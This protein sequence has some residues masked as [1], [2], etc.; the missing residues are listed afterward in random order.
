[1]ASSLHLAMFWASALEVMQHFLPVAFHHGDKA[2]ATAA[3]ERGTE[4]FGRVLLEGEAPEEEALEEEASEEEAL[5]EEALAAEVVA[6]TETITARIDSVVLSTMRKE[7]HQTDKWQGV[8]PASR[9]AHTGAILNR[10][11]AEVHEVVVPA[12][13]LL[14]LLKKAAAV[15]LVAE[16][17]HVIA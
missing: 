5:E 7:P 1:M 10:G 11:E 13:D 15:D 12:A 16:V 9:G 4:E 6:M 2:T 8:A 3:A 17:L 14:P